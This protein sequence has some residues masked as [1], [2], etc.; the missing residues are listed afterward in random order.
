[1]I[2]C[3]VPPVG[4]PSSVRSQ[5]RVPTA[6]WKSELTGRYYFVRLLKKKI[7]TPYKVLVK[8]IVKMALSATPA[9]WRGPNTP[10]SRSW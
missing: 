2:S 6:P 8:L 1:M 10:S 4:P 3:Y 7:I 9:G 5:V